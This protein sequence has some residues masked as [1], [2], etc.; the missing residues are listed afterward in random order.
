MKIALA[1]LNYTIGDFE[2]NTR[3]II[4]SIHTAR[5]N[6]AELIVFSELAV[7]GYIP[8]DLLEQK[9]FIDQAYASIE[10]IRPHCQGIA[11]LIGAPRLNNLASGKKLVNAA[12]FIEAS[13]I[14]QTFIK[15]L[16]PTYDI[17]DDY[18]YFEPNHQFELLEY[19][20]HKIAV[21][22][23]EDLWDK[24]EAANQ[25]AREELYRNSPLS[26]M[27]KLKP[28]FIINIAGSPFSYNQEQSRRNVLAKNAT[29]YHL[30]L[31]Y[32]NQVGANT[33]LIYDGG[34]MVLNS[35]GDTVME[36]KSFQ[37]DLQIIDT[38]TIEKK[39]T[40]SQDASASR[41]EKI[42][43]ALLLGTKD[44]F[45]KMGFKSAVLGLSGGI[46]SALTAYIA[47]EALGPENLT[48]ILLPSPYSSQH[49]LD[50]AIELSE[51]LGIAHH[52][53]HIDTLFSETKGS[54]KEIFQQRQ[55]D[56]TE[57]NIQARIRG[58]LL[59]AVSNKFGHILLNT[60]NKSEAAVGYSTLYGDMNGGLSVL[61]DVYKTDVYKL[62]EHLN[63]ITYRIPLNSIEKPPSAELRPEQKDSDSLPD[64]AILDGI[65]FEY[66]EK[67]Q[68]ASEIIRL[69]YN[70][71][72]V[73]KTIRLVNKTEYKRFQAPPILR[74]SSKAFGLGRRMP[75]VAKY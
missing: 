57:E 67:K 35:A 13:E 25:F 12:L 49:S 46:D 10:K 11:A 62:A 47:A 43:Q 17:F 7:C 55:E 23:C 56:V 65:L 71:A 19:K 42:H 53:I 6:G 60:S 21:T 66:I 61:G 69:G 9:D 41:I 14:K 27:S 31:I 38:D 36:L 20:G 75:I 3:K 4:Q 50:D 22:I 45:C 63:S 73:E 15:S 1:Q 48:G 34:S 16:L 2:Q 30:A 26:E 8:H 33:E 51:N 24:Q 28:D 52:T 18:R 58:M 54:L 40:I 68:S 5:N 70:K 37:E 32:V 74:I 64:Y 59:M 39:A 29:Q 44:Y 72:E